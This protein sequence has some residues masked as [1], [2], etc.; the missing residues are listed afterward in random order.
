MV[1]DDGHIRSPLIVF[2]RSALRRILLFRQ[3]KNGVHP[4]ASKSKLK[5]DSHYRSHRFIYINNGGKNASSSGV[6]SCKVLTSPGVADTCT[7]LMNILNTLPESYQQMVY[8]HTH[9]T[10]KRQIQQVW[11]PLPP[12]VIS[13]EAVG[14]DTAITHDSATSDGAHEKTELGST[15]QN[16]LNDH[17]C[18]DYQ[19]HF[20][21]PGDSRDY[22][23]EGD[24][25]KQAQCHPHCEPLMTGPQ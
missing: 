12:V 14:G 8:T 24:E 25:R 6:P 21:M 13:V 1:K 23:D 9:A 10:V 15:D 16:I 3:K 2:A 22:R 17:N 18:P 11:N 7:F 19:L 5:E 4:K 20:G